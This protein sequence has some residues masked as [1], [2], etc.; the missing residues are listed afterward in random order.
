MQTSEPRLSIVIATFNAVSTLEK[1]LASIACQTF[2]DLEIIIADGLSTDGTIAII[3]KYSDAIAHWH[4]HKDNGIYDAWNQAIEK[5]TGEYICFIGADDYF[6]NEKS[7]S[8]IF[9]AIGNNTYDLISF[10]GTFIQSVTNKKYIIGASWDYE[11]LIKMPICHPGLL[12]HKSLFKKVGTFDTA[13][14]IASDY[15]FM[16][17]L[18]KETTSLHLIIPLIT[19]S[20]GGISRN[21]YHMQMKE[22]WA[23]RSKNP[24]IGKIKATFHYLNKLW[25]VP[26]ARVLN[27]PY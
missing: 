15:D 2:R 24:R 26:I 22:K 3:E 12:H 25:R 10:Q 14:Q 11:C 16:L 5:A 27:I 21:K 9:G 8:I 6:T 17:K 13:F 23:I 19:I 18:P 7:L 1:C 20:D 4:S